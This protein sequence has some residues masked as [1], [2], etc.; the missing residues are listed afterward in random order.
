MT[1]MRI[2]TFD[3][4]F[5]QHHNCNI[6]SQIIYRETF[7]FKF[8]F[9]SFLFF[10]LQFWFRLY[11]VHVLEHQHV[12]SKW[13]ELNNTN[14]QNEKK[15]K[16]KF[17]KY[18]LVSEFK[19]LTNTNEINDVENWK[20]RLFFLRREIHLWT[21]DDQSNVSKVFFGLF[22]IFYLL[23]SFDIFLFICEL[24]SKNKKNSFQSNW[25]LHGLC[26]LCSM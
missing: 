21:C 23:L 5:L 7:V 8:F 2:C 10:A 19:V 13:P 12:K 6:S 26:M 18:S 9:F 14:K 1:H 4:G 20:F 25:N 16:G 17:W 11:C 3:N 15:K 22:Y 24:K